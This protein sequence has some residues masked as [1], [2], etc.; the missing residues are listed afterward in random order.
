MI[1]LKQT[2]K[3]TKRLVFFSPKYIICSIY[4]SNISAPFLP[5]PC[6]QLVQNLKWVTVLNVVG[7]SKYIYR[8]HP[9]SYITSASPNQLYIN[10]DQNKFKDI[11]SGF[12]LVGT[13]L[14]LVLGRYLYYIRKP[15]TESTMKTQIFLHFQIPMD[16]WNIT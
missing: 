7:F 1:L 16:E 14:D 5:L 12:T 8:V 13:L 6:E 10:N 3:R 9:V 15:K 2:W 4:D 11:A